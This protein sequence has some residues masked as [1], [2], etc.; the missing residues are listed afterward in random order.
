MPGSENTSHTL[1]GALPLLVELY[2]KFS[3]FFLIWLLNCECVFIKLITYGAYS[4]VLYGRHRIV[5]M[6]H[7]P[8]FVYISQERRC[9]SSVLSSVEPGTFWAHSKC[10]T[11]SR[12]CSL[13]PWK[14]HWP[15]GAPS[16][17]VHS[18]NSSLGIRLCSVTAIPSLSVKTCSC[19]FQAG[20]VIS[21]FTF[22][23]SR[24]LSTFF[25]FC[26]YYFVASSKSFLSFP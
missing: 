9:V 18:S 26:H 7:F 10:L 16:L 3:F 17:A 23:G 14:R 2:S 24:T 12:L 11:S 6:E 15:P 21:L 4:P 22:R 1:Q 5:Q 13:S 25:F 20:A 8:S 19:S